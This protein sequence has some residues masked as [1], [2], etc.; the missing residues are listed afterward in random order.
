MPARNVAGD[1][2]NR[3]ACWPVRLCRERGQG[4]RQG[5][6]SWSDRSRPVMDLF[7]G[8]RCGSLVSSGKWFAGAASH[9]GSVLTK[10]V[11]RIVVDPEKVEVLISKRRLREALIHKLPPGSAVDPSAAETEGCDLVHLSVDA[12]LRHCGGEVR[13]VVPPRST[14]DMPT[15]Q[16]PSLLK[17]VVR[18]HDWRTQIIDGRVWGR[19][20]LSKQTGLDE[21]YVSRILQCAFLAPDIVEAILDERQPADFSIERLRTKLPLTWAEQ[22]QRFGFP[23]RP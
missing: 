5:D 18:G 11:D 12:R 14:G 6:E 20:T 22:R 15:R 9:S 19:R 2:G 4:R 23:A 3:S 16:V 7:W 10:F 1:Q 17:A 8:D 21:R 13:F